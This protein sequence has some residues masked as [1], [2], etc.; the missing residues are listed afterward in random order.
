MMYKYQWAQ[1][2]TSLEA[3]LDLNK[4]C[5]GKSSAN[6]LFH[7]TWLLPAREVES[8]VQFAFVSYSALSYEYAISIDMERFS[9]RE[10]IYHSGA[11]LVIAHRRAA[12]ITCKCAGG[13][14]WP[15]R[16]RKYIPQGGA[17]IE[18]DGVH[19]VQNSVVYRNP[20][21]EKIT[22]NIYFSSYKTF[23]VSIILRGI[24]Q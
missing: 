22:D 7:R 13:S 4:L 14:Q 6:L 23:L 11:T 21:D 12:I 3:A 15:T 2:L 16:D 17:L 1:V 18:Y 19:T 5:S 10:K 20:Q 9:S 8:R 24:E